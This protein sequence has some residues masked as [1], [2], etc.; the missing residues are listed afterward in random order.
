MANDAINATPNLKFKDN[1]TPLE[2][3]SK[4]RVSINPKHWYHFGCPVYVLATPLQQAGG[5]HHKWKERSRLGLYLGRSPQHSRSVA[6]VLNIETGFVSPQFHV[7]FDPTFQTLRQGGRIPDS[8]WQ[9]KAG[10]AKGKETVATEPTVD[11]IP[12]PVPPTIPLEVTTPDVTLRPSIGPTRMDQAAP[13]SEQQPTTAS[14]TEEQR[15][16]LSE[17]E[18]VAHQEMPEPSQTQ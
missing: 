14:P 10:F 9:Q 16:P 15:P 11:D 18:P 7:K 13:Q 5:I 1:L 12:A 2:A 17:G 4:S 6:L 8:S 3:F